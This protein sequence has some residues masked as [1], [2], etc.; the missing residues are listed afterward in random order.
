MSGLC[1]LLKDRRTLPSKLI[2][3]KENENDHWGG[4]YVFIR[5]MSKN[6]RIASSS[7]RNYTKL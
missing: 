7:Y 4:N 6:K 5:F 1:L 2:Q 3:E